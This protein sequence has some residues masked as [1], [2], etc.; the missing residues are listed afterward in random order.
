MSLPDLFDL[1]LAFL[2]ALLLVFQ[3]L[4]SLFWSDD[5]G[6]VSESSGTHELFL[7]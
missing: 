3:E 6:N 5:I 7:R 2:L 4:E 1:G